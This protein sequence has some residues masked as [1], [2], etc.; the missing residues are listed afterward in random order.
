MKV[1]VNTVE[2]LKRI[3]GPLYYDRREKGSH[4][5]A[6]RWDISGTLLL[7]GDRLEP[8]QELTDVGRIDSLTVLALPILLTFWRCSVQTRVSNNNV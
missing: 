3:K 7:A 6:L 1:L 2:L 5:L 8:S 4:G